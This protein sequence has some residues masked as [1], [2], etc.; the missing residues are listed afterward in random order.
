M[1]LKNMGDRNFIKYTIMERKNKCIPEKRCLF[2]RCGEL[3]PAD[4]EF[5]YAE[6]R[7]AD[8]ARE[9]QITAHGIHVLH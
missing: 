1:C 4:R 7:A 6:R 3:L 9:A 2:F 5:L 8:P